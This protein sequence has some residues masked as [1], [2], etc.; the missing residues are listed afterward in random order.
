MPY[1]ADRSKYLPINKI[2]RAFE[3]I[4]ETE[5]SEICEAKS[6]LVSNVVNAK[7]NLEMWQSRNPRFSVKTGL[8]R[9]V[10]K[11]HAGK[12][13]TYSCTFIYAFGL[14]HTFQVTREQGSV[15]VVGNEHNIFTCM[16]ECRQHIK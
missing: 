10:A 15:P 14:V 11:R 13:G 9:I 3:F 1:C 6:A 16:H 12:Q 2:K 7:G 5:K 4:W 8:T